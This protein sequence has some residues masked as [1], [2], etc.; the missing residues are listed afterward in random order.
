MLYT[1]QV[2]GS[3]LEVG[4]GA[5]LL[6]APHDFTA[7]LPVP[8]WTLEARQRCSFSGAE[9][10]FKSGQQNGV[11]GLPYT[12]FLDVVEK[13]DLILASGSSALYFI[14]CALFPGVT[15]ASRSGGTASKTITTRSL[16]L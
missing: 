6:V 3:K 12:K 4:P 16:P 7:D 2:M 5:G 15:G 13:C 11:V 8:V 10:L 9:L 1:H 14:R